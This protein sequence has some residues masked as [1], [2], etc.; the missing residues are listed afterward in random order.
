M[1]H[2]LK[3]LSATNKDNNNNTNNKNKNK[4][5]KCLVQ[6]AQVEIHAPVELH[7]IKNVDFDL[8]KIQT[9]KQKA[10]LLKLCNLAKGSIGDGQYLLL[11]KGELNLH[12]YNGKRTT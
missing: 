4:N 7:T 2:W 12:G 11:S 10:K 8:K 3:E 9:N 1:S 6:S 5:N